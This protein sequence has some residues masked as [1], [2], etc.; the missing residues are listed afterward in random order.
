MAMN[1]PISSSKYCDSHS[2][3]VNFVSH[4]VALSIN[5]YISLISGR[6]L[7]TILYTC[8]Y[9]Y[10][11]RCLTLYTSHNFL[12]SDTPPVMSPTCTQGNVCIV[13]NYLIVVM[14]QTSSCVCLCAL[15]VCD[16]MHTLCVTVSLVLYCSFISCRWFCL[17][18][19]WLQQWVQYVG[20]MWC[21][22]P[23]VWS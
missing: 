3:Y 16:H 9:M 2:L 1:H 8:M 5:L 7:I 19:S 13:H 14:L 4:A 6:N 11:F 15:C 10:S 12:L 23:A 21:S 20:P 22:Q 17:F 18:I